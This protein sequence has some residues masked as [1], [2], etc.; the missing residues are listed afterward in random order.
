MV[1]DDRRSVKGRMRTFITALIVFCISGCASQSTL[2]STPPER[3]TIGNRNIRQLPP[4][5]GSLV[6]RHAVA[7]IGTPYLFGGSSPETGFDC[8]GLVHY[9]YQQS[10]VSVPRT[11]LEQFRAARKISLGEAVEGDLLFFQDQE[12]LSHVGIYIG[13]GQFVHAPT[14]GRRVSVA[15][16]DNDYYQMHLVGV[17]RL[18]P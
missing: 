4:Q 14:S 5:S 7:M 15:N 1:Q 16:L 2:E 12:K 11:S 3:A 10:G 9:S 18:L 17:G 6:A 8:S 13:D